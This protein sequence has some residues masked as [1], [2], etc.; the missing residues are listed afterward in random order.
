[1]NSWN[2]RKK[3]KWI[4]VRFYQ[5]CTDTNKRIDKYLQLFICNGNIKIDVCMC[6]P[7]V[8][9][10]VCD[11]KARGP[12]FVVCDRRQMNALN[13]TILTLIIYRC[14]EWGKW[15]TKTYIESSRNK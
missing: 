7:M 8:N 6:V 9:K 11:L 2:A 5:K 10:D 13:T 12:H 3:K 4:T 14:M 15:K 1:M